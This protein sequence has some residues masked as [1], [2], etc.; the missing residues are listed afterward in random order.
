MKNSGLKLYFLLSLLTLISGCAELFGEDEKKEDESKLSTSPLRPGMGQLAIGGDS[1]LDTIPGVVESVTSLGTEESQETQEFNSPA[2]SLS[3]EPFGLVATTGISLGND[4]TLQNF[5]GK[6]Y[7]ACEMVNRA[8]GFLDFAAKA[9]L[10]TCELKYILGS[11]EEF[12]DGDDHILEVVEEENGEVLSEKFKFNVTTN[13]AGN[14]T[15]LTAS[16]CEDGEQN[17][18]VEKKIDSDGKISINAKIKEDIESGPQGGDQSVESVAVNVS[19]SGTVNDSQEYVGLKTIDVVYSNK[20]TSGADSLVAER[21]TQSAENLFY[22]GHHAQTDTEQ[23]NKY[24]G[25]M[26]ILDKNSDGNEFSL[27]NIYLGDGALAYKLGENNSTT[28]GWSGDTKNVDNTFD[29]FN[30]VKELEN[31]LPEAPT[32]TTVSGF[33]GDEVFDCDAKAE[34]VIDFEDLMKIWEASGTNLNQGSEYGQHGEEDDEDFC[35][36]YRLPQDSY[37]Q[38]DQGTDTTGG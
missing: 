28:Q 10:M 32:T 20:F 37:L 14:I 18:F 7:A 17:L 2:G 21:V 15:S 36:G 3:I 27:E 16:R 30:E 12:Y 25:F 1:T 22:Y 11:Y 9:D 26:E 8:R 38:C 24:A 5:S 23:P 34:L 13:S 29:F 33:T 6:S 4:T 35:S 31:S 19:V